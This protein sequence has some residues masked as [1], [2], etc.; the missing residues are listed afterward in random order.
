MG[1]SAVLTLAVVVD[2]CH[3]P[4][5]ALGTQWLAEGMR[6]DSQGPQRAEPTAAAPLSVGSGPGECLSAYP[7][8]QH[9]RG[10]WK[11]NSIT[12]GG[13]ALATSLD[14]EQPSS[15]FPV[16]PLPYFLQA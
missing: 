12:M 3:N 8:G 13:W 7:W 6:E 5:H 10:S 11:G 2:S 16:R 15:L 14:Q 4:L 1:N 9:H